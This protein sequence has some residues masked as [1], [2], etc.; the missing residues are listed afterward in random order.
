MWGFTALSH[1][2]L[3]AS[4][5]ALPHSQSKMHSSLE[6]IHLQMRELEHHLNLLE[7]RGVELQ[8]NLRVCQ[9]DEQE[10][11]LLADWFSLIHQK[12]MMVRWEAALVYAEKQQNLEEKQADVEDELRCLLSKPERE[13]INADWIREQQLMAEFVTIIEERDH[14]INRMDQDNQ[15]QVVEDK[16]L[17]AMIK[18]KN[19]TSRQRKKGGELLAH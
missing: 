14:I 4:T 7:L 13:W 12:H 15:R 18:R 5:L 11:M 19:S 2:K 17:A 9:N 10:E 3:D 16:L 6:D 1:S 8:R